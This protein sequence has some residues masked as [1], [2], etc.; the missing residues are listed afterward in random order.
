MR[1]SAPSRNNASSRGPRFP[2]ADQ[3]FLHVLPVCVEVSAERCKG[4]DHHDAPTIL[5][6][7][8]MTLSPWVICKAFMKTILVK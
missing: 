2:L 3:A 4:R 5:R 7:K 1:L 8:P 6:L